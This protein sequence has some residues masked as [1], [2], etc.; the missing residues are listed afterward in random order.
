MLPSCL[1]LALLHLLDDAAV[2][3]DRQA[4]L[5]GHGG[6]VAADVADLGRLVLGELGPADSHLLDAGGPGR[7][8]LG[9]EIGV[10]ELGPRDAVAVG[11]TQQPAFQPDQPL[12]DGVE[13]LDQRLDPGV[14]QLQ[15]LQT[16]R[17]RPRQGV[18]GLLVLGRERLALQAGLDQLVLQPAEGAEVGGHAV[19][20]L[21]DAV[22]QLGFH[23]RDR[24]AAAIVEVVVVVI[25]F[26]RF[27]RFSLGL[28]LFLLLGLAGRGRGVHHPVGGV[29]VDDL[30]Q[31]DAVVGQLLAPDHDGLESQGALAQTGDHGVAA[32][33]D[34]LGD[35]D[36]ALA[37][38]QLDRAHLA[39]IHAHRV[40]GAI[41]GG[42]GFRLGHGGV[43]ALG[44][45]AP[46]G[47]LAVLFGLD[48]VDPH[49]RQHGEGVLDLVGGDLLGRQ[50]L[51]QLVHGDVAAGLGLFD[52]F[53]DAGVSQVEQRTVLGGLGVR[54]LGLGSHSVFVSGRDRSADT[55]VHP[56]RAYRPA[57]MSQM[58]PVLI[59]RRSASRSAFSRRN[60]SS[61][62]GAALTASR[63]DSSAAT[64]VNAS[65]ACDQRVRASA[66]G[67]SAARKGAPDFAAAFSTSRNRTP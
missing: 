47:L 5:G 40:V 6:D 48:D 56:R 11:Q 8:Q 36:L 65:N 21:H 12:V 28:R 37:A 17:D 24:Q 62:P 60:V 34:A 30:A 67:L 26:R 32:G 57:D 27:R 15:G 51:V 41:V 23:G 42:L 58:S 25:A 33:L 31:Q 10:Q 29:E 54:R 4:G 43:G 19:Q 49:L 3:V 2:V 16:V 66:R 52:E 46:G 35:G 50:H 7:V 64:R 22:A 13:L 61:R 39:Q 20:H 45:L 44:H 14:V 55:T 63:A 59:A 9:P 53:L 18:I 38:E 1:A